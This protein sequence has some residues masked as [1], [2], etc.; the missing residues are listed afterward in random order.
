MPQRPDL[1]LAE[2]LFRFNP[3]WWWD[4][5]PPWFSEHLTIA[6][7]RELTRIQLTKQL[8]VLEAEQAAVQETLKVIQKVK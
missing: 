7:A 6:V 5:I 8:R 3:K 2:S 4:P 1:Q